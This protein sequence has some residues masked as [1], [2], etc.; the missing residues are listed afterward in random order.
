MFAGKH[1]VGHAVET[2]LT[3]V[4][5]GRG[6][7]TVTKHT[8]IRELHATKGWRT[9]QHSTHTIEADRAPRAEDS[10]EHTTHIF[11]RI[12]PLRARGEYGRPITEK[13][14]MRHGWYR[15][16]LAKGA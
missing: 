16:Q 12:R 13:M 2:S 1:I 14:L 3:S 6:R 8:F 10:K 15:R 9:K 11:Q 4:Q 5:A 7:Y